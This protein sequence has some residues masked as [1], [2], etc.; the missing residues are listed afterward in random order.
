MLLNNVYRKNPDVTRPDAVILQLVRLSLTQ[1]D[2]EFNG[3][4][5]LQVKGTAMGKRFALS[6]ANIYIAHWEETVFPKCVRQP[7]QYFRFLDDIWGVLPHSR[8]DFEEFLT[9]LNSHHRSITVTAT[10]NDTSIDFLDTTTFKG[11]RFDST[12]QWTMDKTF[13]KTDRYTCP[14]P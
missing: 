14:A 7:A 3:E 13:R 10:L 1:N 2:F 11:P 8:V 4:F 6:Y 12:G 9:T 5:Y